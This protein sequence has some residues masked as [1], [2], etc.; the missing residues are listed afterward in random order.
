MPV[1]TDNDALKPHLEQFLKSHG[2]RFEEPPDKKFCCPFHEDT[3]PSMN[4]V[5]DSNGTAA[6]CF[7]CDANADIFKFAAHFYGLDIKRDFREIKKRVAVELRQEIHEAVIKPK[8]EKPEKQLEKPV[9]L[10]VSAARAVY[11]QTAITELGKFVFGEALAAGAELK[12]EKVWPCLNEAGDVEFV[13]VRFDPS[14]F[15]NGKKRP[16]VMWWNGKRL[17]SKSNP[18]GLFGRDLLAANP[19]KPVLIV[20][21]PKCQEA[22][23]ALADFVPVA[24]NGGAQGQKKVDF[25][26]LRGRRVYI[27]PDDDEAGGKS[28][29]STAK[30]LQGIANEIIIVEPLPEAR[31][32]KPEKADIVE[33]LQVKTPE[34]ITRYILNH[35]PPA[36]TPKSND[37]YIRAGLFLAERGFFKVY[38]KKAIG[39]YSVN[40]EQP[41]NYGEIRDKFA[42]DKIGDL[43]P[44]K[45]AKMI[46]NLDPA[47]PVYHLVKSFGYKPMFMGRNGRKNE[48]IINRWRGFQ[49]PQGEAPPVDPEIEAEVEFVKAHIKDIICGGNDADYDYLCK[50]IAHMFQRPDEKPGTAVFAHSDAHGTGKSIIFEKLIPNMLGVGITSVFTNKEQIAEKFNSWLFESLY[51][52]FSEQSF[53]EHT[54]NIKSWITE[55]YHNRRGMGIDSQPDRSFARFIICTNNASA[56]RFE[57]TER[58]MFTPNVSESRLG[59]DFYFSRLAKAVNSV[60]VID[61]MARFFCS[62]DIK[63]WNSYNLPKSQKKQELISIEKH[64]VIDFFERVI[65]GGFPDFGASACSE[66]DPENGNNYYASKKIYETLKELGIKYGG[67]LFMERDRLYK[68]WKNGEGRNRRES[69]NSFT[70]I[71]NSYYKLKKTKDE[72]D[73]KIVLLEHAVK[74][75]GRTIHPYIYLI[76]K[77]FV[78]EKEN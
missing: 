10:S 76:K 34:E 74:E 49:Y 24:W 52:V 2:V 15:A 13:E 26:P 58:R 27:W 72:P 56:F 37:P 67:L 62:I 17:K 43:N 70:R 20:E 21:G 60:S 48:Y 40:E 5:P 65:F 11:T 77:E 3:E 32:I 54:E 18:H 36:E 9:T 66:I 73:D 45:A 33:A 28:A 61:R 44:A 23:K 14:C 75:G 46:D 42:E 71:I 51:V 31:Q 29:R 6:H 68:Y 22:A 35:T 25:S 19:E 30:L 4:I 39:F 47:Y 64:P 59:D 53:Y 8:P 41:Y 78:D 12:I 57:K 38:D 7:A 50:W 63:G 16:C 69:P 1:Y 55:E